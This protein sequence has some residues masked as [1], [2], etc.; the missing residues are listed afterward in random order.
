MKNEKT[1]NVALNVSREVVRE[2]FDDVTL[3]ALIL[4]LALLHLLHTIN[5]PC[6]C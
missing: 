2:V 3:S 4:I 5:N 6:T 1:F